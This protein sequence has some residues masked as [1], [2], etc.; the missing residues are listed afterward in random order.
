MSMNMTLN[1]YTKLL[2]GVT[3]SNAD[4]VRHVQP[5]YSKLGFRPANQEIVIHGLIF[6][7]LGSYNQLDPRMMALANETIEK[8]SPL[9]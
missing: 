7:A 1:E 6:L 8:Y 2:H 3:N 9:I 4:F 5:L